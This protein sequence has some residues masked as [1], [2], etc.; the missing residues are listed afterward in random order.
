[1]KCIS[2]NNKKYM[3]EPTFINLHPKEC[4]QGSLY[5]LSTVVN[6]DGCVGSCNAGDGLSNRVCVPNK[7][8]KI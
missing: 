2:I 6:L 1:M 3:T 4:I 5:Y 8:Q 7:K